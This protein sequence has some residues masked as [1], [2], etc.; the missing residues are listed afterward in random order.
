MYTITNDS[1]CARKIL[2]F[3]T[4][5]RARTC[6]QH[7]QPTHTL[8][9]F[10]IH[11]EIETT[12]RHVYILFFESLVQ[13]LLSCGEQYIGLSRS[14]AL[15]DS[16]ASPWGNDNIVLNFQK[17]KCASSASNKLSLLLGGTSLL[18]LIIHLLCRFT[19]MDI[20]CTKSLHHRR[21]HDKIN[22]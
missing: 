7:T 2:K 13:V 6:T 8:T 3:R 14:T 9:L 5:T 17:L 22:K 16:S 11:K 10:C 20:C 18:S 15:L 19:V 4:H 1:L 21:W 12:L